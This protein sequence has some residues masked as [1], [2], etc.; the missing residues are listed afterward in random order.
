MSALSPSATWQMVPPVAG[1]MAGKVLPETLSTNLPPMNSGWSFTTGGLTR[2]GFFVT[3]V[4]MVTLL[5]RFAFVPSGSKESAGSGAY[6]R[7]PVIH[8]ATTGPIA[9][10]TP[11]CLRV[12]PLA[13][14]RRVQRVAGDLNR[15]PVQ[16]L[17]RCDVQGLAVRA[18]EGQVRNQV[19]QD[20]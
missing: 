20:R 14:Q 9:T 11:W 16:R 8:Y 1:L 10:N 7:P 12:A 3:A 15:Q 4:D 5:S 18:T 2:R 19:L 6:D 13:A 17:A